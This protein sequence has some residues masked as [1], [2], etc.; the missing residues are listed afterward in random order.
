MESTEI[1]KIKR[2]IGKHRAPRNPRYDMNMKEALAVTHELTP[3][4]AVNLAF[5]YGRAKGYRAAKKEEWA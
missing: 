1:E 3:I 5:V 4:E 2:Y